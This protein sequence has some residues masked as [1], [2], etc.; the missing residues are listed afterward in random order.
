MS[1]VFV[2]NLMYWPIPRYVSPAWFRAT[3]VPVVMLLLPVLVLSWPV[4][5]AWNYRGLDS[6]NDRRRIRVLVAGM[7]LSLLVAGFHLFLV[8]A[9]F[10]AR[11][12]D[13][14]TP[15]VLDFGVAKALD[16]GEGTTSQ[17][18]TGT[19][20]LVGTLAYMSPEQLQG[21]AP[22]PA[23]DV[24]A[25]TVIAYEMLAGVHPFAAAGRPLHAAV[26]AGRPAPPSQHLGDDGRRWD[27][28]F[29]TAL[30]ADPRE[31]PPTARE[32]VAFFEATAV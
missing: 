22:E 20:Q 2:Y 17:L 21:G 1:W 10:L 14:E 5:L 12:G 23:W 27:A 15:K 18:D 4:L 29:A 7:A 6:P 3:V 19:G 31:R 11:A 8:S 16:A 32:L 26:L 28:L 25:L 13:G 24:W 9:N 30:G